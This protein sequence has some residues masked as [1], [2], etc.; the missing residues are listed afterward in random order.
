MTRLTDPEPAS[1]PL[2]FGAL[3][4]GTLSWAQRIL[5]WLDDNADVAS[6]KD[7]PSVANDPA[8]ERVVTLL[9]GVIAVSNL[10]VESATQAAP[11]NAAPKSTVRADA[12]RPM[13]TWRL[14]AR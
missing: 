1:V 13:R 14:D 4:L 7:S 10:V 6:S 9:L 11:E 12:P 3:A 8:R 2:G 5:T